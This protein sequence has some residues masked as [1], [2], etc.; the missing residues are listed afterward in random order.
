MSR[1][2]R[3][4][5]PPGVIPP[6]PS[7]RHP[8]PGLPNPNPNPNPPVTAQE[9]QAALTA[10]RR[11]SSSIA[12]D[13][14]IAGNSDPE[15]AS[16]PRP[17][18]PAEVP[19]STANSAGP[20]ASGGLLHPLATTNGVASG[21]NSPSSPAPYVGPLHT[22]RSPKSQ[23]IPSGSSTA[24]GSPAFHPT[25]APIGLS[26]TVPQASTDSPAIPQADGAD[27]ESPLQIAI[28]PR[29]AVQD[30][31]TT[32]QA[33]A[34]GSVQASDPLAQAIPAPDLTGIANLTIS[35]SASSH[36]ASG[37]NNTSQ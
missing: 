25:S 5:F 30:D 12:Y 16:I 14:L 7:R 4:H 3:P 18:P 34:P 6:S 17:T 15:A 32:S 33:P 11:Q 29:T 36:P 21:V 20:F 35:D 23:E 19:F 28:N 8:P 22:L 2:N 37:S 13:A 27:S 9:Q 10:L 26:S 31:N 1:D 24:T